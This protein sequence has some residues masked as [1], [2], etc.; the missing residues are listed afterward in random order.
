MKSTLTR[1]VPLNVLVDTAYKTILLLASMDI[2]PYG[3]FQTPHLSFP[4]T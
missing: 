2:I 4:L 1:S 3:F